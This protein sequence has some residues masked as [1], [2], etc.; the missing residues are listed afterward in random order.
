MKEVER[1][2]P[3]K[4]LMNRDNM[5]FEEAKQLVIECHFTRCK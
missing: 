1:C 4:I 5:T 3:I 2:R